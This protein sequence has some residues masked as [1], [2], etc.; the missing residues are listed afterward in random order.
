MFTSLSLLNPI[1]FKNIFEAKYNCKQTI[2]CLFYVF[3]VYWDNIFSIRT[4]FS[5]HKVPS[6]ML[7]FTAQNITALRKEL[8]WTK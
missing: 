8:S 7:K 3:F 4:T 6:Y 5:I 1:L 2:Y